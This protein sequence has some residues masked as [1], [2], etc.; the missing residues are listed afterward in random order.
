MR[1]ANSRT[2]EQPDGRLATEFFSGPIFYRPAGSVG[3]QP[4]DLTLKQPAPGAGADDVAAAVD[5][6]PAQLALAA[7]DDPEGFIR[8]AG[9][10]HQI[11]FSLP[12]GVEPGVAGTTAQIGLEGRFADYANFLPGGIGLRVF[13]R[14]DGVK[15]FL[16]LPQ[17]P[18]HTSF[19]FEVGAPGLTLEPEADGTLAFHDTVGNVVG[20]IPRPFMV[21]SSDVEG[22]GGGI[23]SEA[24]TLS[25]AKTGESSLITLDIDPAF[26]E[27]AVYPVYV[28]PTTTSFPTG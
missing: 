5:S 4:I 7:A 23:Y 18:A 13:P 20:R 22:R 12:A 26:L 25:L 19:S 9:D 2:F 6:S 17:K 15:T 28:D 10:G 21:D 16:I 3:W 8:L 1:T 24:V 27:T 11:S 14:V